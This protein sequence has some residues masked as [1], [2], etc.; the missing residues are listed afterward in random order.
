[1]AEENEKLKQLLDAEKLFDSL[2]LCKAEEKRV[3]R[4]EFFGE[5]LYSSV[6]QGS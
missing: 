3:E 5:F 6:L 4:Q 1:M 2:Q